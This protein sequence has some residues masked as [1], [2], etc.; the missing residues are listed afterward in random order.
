M[1]G[2]VLTPGERDVNFREAA[3]KLPSLGK[4]GEERGELGGCLVNRSAWR[5]STIFLAWRR[6]D[7]NRGFY[8]TAPKQFHAPSRRDN[9]AASLDQQSDL[10][11]MM[12]RQR[13]MCF[14]GFF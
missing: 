8:P 13:L 2:P 10:A 5:P 4:E 11:Q 6:F 1:T 7:G 9:R 14:P 3:Q 12:F